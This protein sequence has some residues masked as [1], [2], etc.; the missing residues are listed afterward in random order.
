VIEPPS[1]Y[2]LA[3][4]RAVAAVQG[5][6]ALVYCTEHGGEIGQIRTTPEGRLFWANVPVEKG[7]GVPAWRKRLKE[8]TGRRARPAVYQVRVLIEM[9]D[10][11][12]DPPMAWCAGSAQAHPRP[13]RFPVV[14]RYVVQR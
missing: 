9:M 12:P 11:A 14:Q 10:E 7:S 2:E 13:R 1:D 4:A 6:Q 5:T 8:E 3:R